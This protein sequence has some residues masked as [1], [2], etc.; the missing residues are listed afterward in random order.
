MSQTPL[1]GV[2]YDTLFPIKEEDDEEENEVKEKE[3]EE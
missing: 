2:L 3:E 1:E